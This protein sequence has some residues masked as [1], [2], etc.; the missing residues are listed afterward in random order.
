MTS[1]TFA[2]VLLAVLAVLLGACGLLVFAV[3]PYFHYRAPRTG[4]FAYALDNQR[5]QNDGIV[6]HFSY[7]ALVTGS[8]MTEN[9]KA[10]DVERLW[11]L[12]TV[13]VPFAGASFRELRRIVQTAGAANRELELVIVG[14]DVNKLL[15]DRDWMRNDLGAFPDYLYDD[16]PFNDVKYLLNVGAIT[17]SVRGLFGPAGMRTTFDDYSRWHTEKTRYGA[18]AGLRRPDEP[19]QSA[20]Q[21]PFTVDDDRRARDNAVANFAPM[22]KCTRRLLLF[23]TPYSELRMDCWRREGRYGR[24]MAAKRAFADE[25]RKIPNARLFD[26]SDDREI[27]DNPENYRDVDHYGPWVNTWIFE[28]MKAAETVNGER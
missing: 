2:F 1:R 3:D 10:S 26:F 22:A 23:F 4:R 9:F 13:K 24:F 7:R 12:P 11:G 18:A 6:R 21:Q 20:A 28:R 25:I 16:N 8:S 19:V 17:A 5:G 15:M 14:V 27:V